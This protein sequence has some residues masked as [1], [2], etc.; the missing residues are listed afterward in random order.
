ML[1]ISS[2]ALRELKI[3]IILI[4]S[5]KKNVRDEINRV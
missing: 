2:F 3:P 5:N 4:L 1:V